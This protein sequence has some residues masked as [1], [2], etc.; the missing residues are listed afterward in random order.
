MLEFACHTWAFADLTLME[1]LGT[2]ARLG[3]RYVD[4]GSGSNLNTQR[5]AENPR[6]FAAEIRQ[7]LEA[8]NLKISDLYLLLPR[9]S[10][11]DE[12]KRQK[13]LDLYRAL[14]PF[15]AALGAPGISLSPGLAQPGEDVEAADR[16]VAALREMVNL[17]KSAGL[18]VSI[19]PHLDSMAQTPEQALKLVKDVPG[20]SLTLDWAHMVCQD[21]FHEDI[22]RLLPHVKHLQVRQAARA[23][24]QTPF[25]QGRIDIQRL[26]ADLIAAGY[27]GIICVEYM[28]TPGWHGMLPVNAIQETTRMRDALRAA[29]DGLKTEHKTAK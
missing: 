20:L 11:A 23:Q 14:L 6:Q 3:F 12:S 4:L 29:R 9:I 26:V 15:A 13:D 7:D 24:L 28:N 16:V 19:E 5:A 17:G 22:L 8:F 25:E 10:L 2:I 1:A 27:D 18:R 21:I